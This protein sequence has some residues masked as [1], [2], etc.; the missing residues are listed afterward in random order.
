VCLLSSLLLPACGSSPPDDILE[1]SG[2]PA[3]VFVRENS[4]R[5][6]GYN[7]MK[8]NGDEYYPGTDLFLLSPI[9]PQ[10]DLVNLTAQFTQ[11]N[12]TNQNNFGAVADPEVSFDGRKILFS[13]REN[14]SSRWS[15]YEMNSDG[16]GLVRLTDASS[17]DDMD[18]AYLPNGQI[19]FTSTRSGIVDE[20]ERRASPLL[21]VADRGADGRLT[22]VRQISFNQSHDTNPIVHSSGKVLFSRWE[23]LGNP[24]KFPLFVINPDGTRLFVMYGNHS[25]S[26]SGSRVFLEPRELADGGIVC[27]VM[28]RNSPFEGGAL[29]IVDI[30]KSDDNLV[31]VTPGTAPFNNTGRPTSA[32]YKTPYPIIDKN[33]P[34]DNQE[35]IL[36]AMSPIPVNPGTGGNQVDYGIYVM[37]KDGNNTRLVYNDPG[38]NEIDP[39]VVAPRNL[40]QVIPPDPNV[41][42]GLST[43]TATG[44]FFDGNVYD[45]APNDGQTRP[46][47]TLANAD[48]TTGQARY[49]RVLEAIPLPR[50]GSMR[51]GPIGNTN[52]EK[53]RVIGYA[54]VRSDGSFSIEVPANRSLHL[55]TLDETGMMLVNQLTWIQVMP[56]ERRLCTGCHDS[57]DRDRIINDLQVQ[58]TREVFNK[59]SGTTYESGFHNAS[60]V[61]AH[62]AARTDTVDFFDRAR[63]TRAN[64]VQAVFDAHCVSCHGGTAPSGGLRLENHMSDLQPPSS[65][66]NDE[67]SVY[68]TLTSVARYRTARNTFLNYVMESGARRSPL[69]WVMYNRQL[70]DPSGAD[71]RPLSYDHSQLWTKDQFNR[72]DPFLLANR[73]LLTIIEW[74]DMGAQFSN[75]VAH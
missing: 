45:R 10:G 51:G 25:P 7:A 52:F 9:S 59:A 23:H 39:V 11:R 17:W 1:K 60:L 30:S 33:A 4:Q 71:F 28:E 22:N 20:Y 37:D 75:T 43:G 72:I 62:A 53:Q 64:T 29:A 73:D 15:V 61:T 69:A 65:T 12:Q 31:F 6:N 74:V 40:P 32:L 21:H 24:N 16:S 2:Q 34:A 50:S 48:G 47:S 66:M 5:N 36:F 44:M 55:Q 14:R 19:L 27:S 38:F 70:N 49:V 26:A 42:A 67:T 68:D 58:P 56:G 35:K 46:S 3:L 57:H 63:P 18:P 8:S 13:M 41:A 54:P